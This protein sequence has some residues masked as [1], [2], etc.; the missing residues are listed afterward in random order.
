[1]A[2]SRHIRCPA[3]LALLRAALPCC[4]TCTA[5]DPSFPCHSTKDKVNSPA[6]HLHLH[7][8]CTC[9]AAS[10]SPSWSPVML[11]PPHARTT[12]TQTLRGCHCKSEEALGQHGP[13]KPYRMYC[14]CVHG[15]NSIH[16]GRLL[17]ALFRLD[18]LA[19]R[20][21][22]SAAPDMTDTARACPLCSSKSVVLPSVFWLHRL[23]LHSIRRQ[24]STSAVHFACSPVR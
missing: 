6:L 19:P 8:H 5:F 10:L 9:T 12:Q 11:P 1:M 17:C 21:A 15:R 4:A 3:P 20:C 18:P 14:V 22:N 13:G 2:A 16:A 7:L 24:P 23:S